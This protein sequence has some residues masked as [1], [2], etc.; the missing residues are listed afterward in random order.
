[1]IRYIKIVILFILP[2]GVFG[3]LTIDAKLESIVLT[4]SN[5]KL[6]P[7]YQ[8]SNQ[9][10][11][12]SPFEQSQLLFLAG[13]NSKLVDKKNFNLSVGFA[14]L[15]KDDIGESIVHEAYVSGRAFKTIDFNIGKKAYSP[16]SI[17]DQLTS[18][19]FMMNSNA[20]PIPKAVI[21]IFDYIPVGFLRNNFEVKG[22]LSQGILNE[23]RKF[24][25][26]TNTADNV[27]VHEKW[28][29]LKW[30]KYRIKPYVGLYHGAL[31]GG[32]R[33]DGTKVPIDFWATFT[34]SGSTAIGGGDVT[35]A[36]GAHDGFWDFG[37]NYEHAIGNFH[38]YIQ[39]PFADGSGLFLNHLRNHDYKIGV[40]AELND[41]DWLK[42][43]SIELIKTDY[44]SGP[45]W[46][47]PVYPPGKGEGYIWLDEVDDYDAFMKD[48]FEEETEGWTSSDVMKYMEVNMNQG[49]K[50]GGRDNYNNNGFYYKAWSYNNIGMGLP[51][52]Q[53]YYQARVFA[54]D[55]QSHNSGI[56]VNNRVKGFHLGLNGSLFDYF[57]YLF[58][59]T[60]SYNKGSY[61]EKY[62]SAYSWEE[63]PEFYYEN[64]KNQTYT[65][66]GISYQNKKWKDLSFQTSASYD[67]G[68]LYHSFG[69]SLGVSYRPSIGF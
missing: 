37:F 15:I 59:S 12:A 21:G 14:G 49:H 8:Y 6:Q 36:A 13:A 1:M 27:L 43:V 66:L 50:F 30:S 53:T 51:L 20:R 10:G 17:N 55:W 29:Y 31:F 32:T 60:Y 69:F 58:K 56:F 35:N 2:I 28:A 64:G 5:S 19:G 18:G 7:L 52:Y 42:N 24:E 16:I 54:P 45:G 48:V 63:E 47:D 11:I 25:G 23:D 39:K 26:K 44:Q 65:Y 46:T 57:N 22:G 38:F 40:Y 4:S 67:F 61:Y 34:A 33:P 62:V 9:W 3:Q 68:Q 41:I